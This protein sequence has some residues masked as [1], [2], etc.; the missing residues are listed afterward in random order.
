MRSH[1]SFFG[2]ASLLKGIIKTM[3]NKPTTYCFKIDF[4]LVFAL[5]GFSTLM[6][7]PVLDRSYIDEA[8]KT[9]ADSETVG[10]LCLRLADHSFD[11]AI[12]T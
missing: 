7:M 1:T 9:K 11:S 10:L 4:R 6:F 12:K 3:I 2:T 5:L 8:Y